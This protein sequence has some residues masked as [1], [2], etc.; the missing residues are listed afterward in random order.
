MSPP[1]LNQWLSLDLAWW[2]P[3]QLARGLKGPACAMLSF[4]LQTGCCIL[5]TKTQHSQRSR[6][7]SGAALPCRRGEAAPCSGSLGTQRICSQ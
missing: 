1:L 4:P 6:R 3:S 2:P 7:A 5:G